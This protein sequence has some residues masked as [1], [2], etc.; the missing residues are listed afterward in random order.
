[1]N[2]FN[3]MLD[4]YADLVVKVGVNVQPGQ[5]LMVQAPLETVELTRLIVSKAYKAG[6][7]YVQVEWEDE[8]VTRIRYEQAADD[9]FGY[10]P[11]WQADM[12]EQLAEG[13]G[14]FYILK[15]RILNCSA[16]LIPLRYQL[17]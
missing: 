9:S 15:Y 6:A 2:E 10:Y 8:Q 4:K 3:L 5:V 7:K 13:G 17:L 11:K 1:M 16:E 12:M 14:A